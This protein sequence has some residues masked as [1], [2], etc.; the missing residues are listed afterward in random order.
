M[1]F[2]SHVLSREFTGVGSYT[3][4]RCDEVVPGASAPLGIDEPIQMPGVKNGLDAILF[5]EGGKVKFLEIVTFG[6][7]PWDGVIDGFSIL[8]VA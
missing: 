4:F 2:R 7:E 8:P 3:N 5:F 6:S 1:L